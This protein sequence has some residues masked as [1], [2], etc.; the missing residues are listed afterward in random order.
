M[1]K[2]TFLL[3]LSCF[4]LIAKDI[5]QKHTALDKQFK[6]YVPQNIQKKCD[7]LDDI[8]KIFYTGYYLLD[9]RYKRDESLKYL[10]ESYEKNA[11]NIVDNME[12]RPYHLATTIAELYEQKLNSAVK[13]FKL[14]IN[15][16]NERMICPLGNIYQRQGKVYQAN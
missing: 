11:S 4:L 10:I 13:F 2:K 5:P 15:A 9:Y 16:G 1:I 8:C 6:H 7:G 12:A 3:Y 14:A